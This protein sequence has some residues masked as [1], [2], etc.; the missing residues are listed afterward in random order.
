[1]L[2]CISGTL[3]AKG[4]R[5]DKHRAK[6]IK[7]SIYANRNLC[8]HLDGRH[9]LTEDGY[10]KAADTAAWGSKIKELVE[11]RVDLLTR[12]LCQHLRDPVCV[13]SSWIL[14]F[15]FDR[16]ATSSLR[17]VM[18]AYNDDRPYSLDLVGAVGFFF[19]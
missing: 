3:F 8:Y 10:S 5:T 4:G 17:R 6:L 9:K 1:M 19:A 11:Y 16:S 18:S 15:A 2:K 7:A 14:S 12:E 13:G